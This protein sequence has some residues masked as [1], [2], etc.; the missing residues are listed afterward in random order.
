MSEGTLDQ[1]AQRLVQTQKE[2][3]PKLRA[4]EACLEKLSKRSRSLIELKYND[5]MPIEKIAAVINS[6][7]GAVRVT[8]FRIRNLLADCIERR[9]TN[10][11]KR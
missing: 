11:S 4:L 1:I 3:A 10:E 2:A 7:P 6:T 9:L 5:S 8:L